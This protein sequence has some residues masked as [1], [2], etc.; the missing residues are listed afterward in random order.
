MQNVLVPLH[1]PIKID[2]LPMIEKRRSEAFKTC[3]FRYDKS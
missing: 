2:I 1:V 3:S